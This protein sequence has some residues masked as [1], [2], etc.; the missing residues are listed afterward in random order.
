MQL[1]A[2]TTAKEFDPKVTLEYTQG[3]S[4]SWL[5]YSTAYKSGG[6]AFA[7]WNPQLMLKS[8]TTWKKLK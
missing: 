3:D 4:L 7:K 8:L 2:G 6:P 5:T 1:T